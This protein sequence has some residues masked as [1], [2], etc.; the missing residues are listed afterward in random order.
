MAD[1]TY[2]IGE[3]TYT[4]EEFRKLTEDEKVEAMLEWFHQHYEDPVHRTPYNSREGGYLWVHGGP[5]DADEEIQSEFSDVVEFQ[6]MQ[7]AVEE[8]TSD[9]L[10]EWG[11]VPSDDYYDD[12]EEYLADENGNSITDENGNRIIVSRDIPEID[13]RKEMLSRLDRLE[14]AIAGYS[15]N[16]PPRNHNNPPELI[17]TEIISPAQMDRAQ[18]AVTA[19]RVETIK[20]VP[21]ANVLRAQSTILSQVGS[22]IWASA[23]VIAGGVAGS[24]VWEA[25][26]WMHNNPKEIYDAIHA[27]A[28]MAQQWADSLPG[29]L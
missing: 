18:Q 3:V 28:Q 19:L 13:Y 21:D 24:A 25:L 14:T 20:E 8:I 11:P 9:G 17:D 12:G 16:L 2:Q 4:A 6:T 7:R 22:A 10:Y 29:F 15:H 26:V 1:H 27:V 23:K 5:Y